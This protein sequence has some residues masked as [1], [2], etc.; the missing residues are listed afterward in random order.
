VEL[1]RREKWTQ[2]PEKTDSFANICRDSM[3]NSCGPHNSELDC[4]SIHNDKC[5]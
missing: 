3:N 2:T 1:S 4:R 5:Y